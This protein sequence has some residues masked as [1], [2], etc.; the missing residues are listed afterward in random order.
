[1][2]TATDCLLLEIY[3]AYLQYHP[4][5]TTRETTMT[6]ATKIDTTARIKTLFNE[7]L[8]FARQVRT[9]DMTE[10]EIA[11]LY[12]GFEGCFKTKGPVAIR[13]SPLSWAGCVRRDGTIDEAAR[14]QSLQSAVCRMLHYHTGRS[15]SYLGTLINATDNLR[16][17]AKAFGLLPHAD[18]DT[19]WFRLEL[20]TPESEAARKLHDENTVVGKHFA[21]G[22]DTFIRTFIFV[23]SGGKTTSTAADEWKRVLS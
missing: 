3:G 1:M 22:V 21:D 19:K 10:Q 2:K 13:K 23:M 11:I 6:T 7:V 18:K 5:T 15:S 14:K 4:V 12:E 9:F 20:G 17:L 8:L 16:C